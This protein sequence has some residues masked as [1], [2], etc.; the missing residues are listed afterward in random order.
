[1]SG[2]PSIATPSVVSL[3][4]CDQ[5]I[6][7]KLTNKKSAIGLF[8]TVVVPKVPTRIHQL[9]IMATLTEITG[10]TPLQVRL[11]RD[12]DN[13]ILMQT[14]GHVD[15]PDPLAMVDLLFAMQGVPIAEV[16]QYAFELVSGGELL[17]R[18][19]F[20]VLIGQQRKPPGAEGG[21]PSSP[22]NPPAPDIP[23]DET[24]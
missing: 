13:T 10:K 16:G 11:I 18:R 17:G 12:S 9:A 15:A 1:M 21:R 2:H 7:D 3:L 22:V 23:P 20:H 4:V 24:E 5:V 19:R 6:D 14:N 8:N